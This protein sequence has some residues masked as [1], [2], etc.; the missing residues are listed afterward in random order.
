LIKSRLL[1]KGYIIQEDNF[2]SKAISLLKE[3]KVLGRIVGREEFGARALGNRSIL[4]DPR[5]PSI[6]KIINE[7]I[8]DRDFWMPFACSVVAEYADNYLQLEAPSKCYSYMTLCCDS[9][10]KEKLSNIQA[11]VHP[12]DETC[13]P[14][15]VSKEAN[16]EYHKLISAFGD[17]TG[18]YALLNTSLNLHGLPIAS[19]LEDALKILFES[20]LDGL[21]TENYLVMKQGG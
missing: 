2:L 13:R 1:A 4:A 19:T 15:L 6:K 11:A 12:Y 21:I 14:H 5:N 8:K 10:S 9:I 17:A 3:G 20:D 7:K 18:T 16:P